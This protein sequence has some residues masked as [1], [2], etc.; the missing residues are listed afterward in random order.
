MASPKGNNEATNQQRTMYSTTSLISATSAPVTTETHL[1]TS[2]RYSHIPTSAICDTLRD[3]GW[4]FSGGT[5]RRARTEVRARH[6]AHVL[7]FRNPSLPEVNGSLIEAVLLNS[8]DGSTAFEL[9]FGVYRLACANGLVVRTATLGAVRLRHSGL[10]LDNV[11]TAAKGL[12]SQAPQVAHL[13]DAWSH[14]YLPG[15]ARSQM[16]LRMAQAR[17]GERLVQ[18]ETPDARRNADLGGDLWT[19]FNRGQEA[20]LRGGIEVTLR[21][22]PLPDGTEVLSTRRAPGIRGSLKQLRL[23]QDLFAIAS[24]FAAQA[25]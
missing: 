24:E 12:V 16:F 6:A 23:N 25:A 11:F 13:V 8:H 10:N 5:T 7:R 20:I 3:A 18:V 9:G 21:R 17:W 4:E 19:V 22:D 2:T 14:L 1:G 15:E